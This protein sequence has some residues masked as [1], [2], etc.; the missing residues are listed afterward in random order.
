MKTTTEKILNYLEN[1][2]SATVEQISHAL[3]LSKADI[4]YHMQQLR[5]TEQVQVCL[6]TYQNGAGRPARRYSLVRPISPQTAQLIIALL[7]EQLSNLDQ[8]K[9]ISN[10]FPQ[11]LANV[12]LQQCPAWK[13]ECLSP[14]IRLNR[15]TQELSRF[16][17]TMIWH[18][19][20]TGP[21]ISFVKEP[22]TQLLPGENLVQKT[23]QSMIM[24]IEERIA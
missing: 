21:R 1:H 24:R 22:L 12:L 20:R 9:Q 19:S 5:K 14:A 3:F 16:G 13:E 2:E 18:A 6:S 4:H 11:R 7:H 10:E 15:L 17:F 23:L 8:R